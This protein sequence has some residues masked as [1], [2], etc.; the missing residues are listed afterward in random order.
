MQITSNDDVSQLGIYAGVAGVGT[1]AGAA[2][3]ARATSPIYKKDKK[4]K[5]A[6]K[7][8]QQVDDAIAGTIMDPSTQKSKR[9]QKADSAVA[10]RVAERQNRGYRTEA[11]AKKAEEAAFARA[12]QSAAQDEDAVRKIWDNPRADDIM[13]AR[14]RNDAVNH[15]YSQKR[16]MSQPALGDPGGSFLDAP[17]AHSGTI[18]AGMGDSTGAG[19]GIRTSKPGAPNFKR[20]AIKVANAIL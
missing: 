18:Y 20:S 4:K 11:G 6:L 5:D 17:Q 15:M 7:A 13:Q 19:S 16:N 1:V 10:E 2:V 8:R 3:V 14:Q 9:Q 12:A